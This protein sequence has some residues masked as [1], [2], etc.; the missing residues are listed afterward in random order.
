MYKQITLVTLIISL[1]IFAQDNSFI[2][3]V[4]QVIGKNTEFWKAAGSDHLFYHSLKPAGQFLL[5]RMAEKGS[6]RY[7]RSHHT[8]NKDLKHGVIRG[9]NV[10]SE[11]QDGNPIYDFSN[12]N[13]VFQSYVE[14]GIKPI[15]EYDYL[16]ELL[17]NNVVES[18]SGNDEGMTIINTGPN[19]WKKWSDL[20]KAITQNFI[21][22]V[23][24]EEVRSWFLRFGM[25]RMGGLMTN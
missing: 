21:D 6:H 19:D 1:Q 20:M 11:D 14:N 10:Y 3:E 24:T 4:N 25:N 5:K 12:I 23:G 7:L 8:F 18:S 16:P 9:Q 13:K 2:I 15:V 17:I 22:Q